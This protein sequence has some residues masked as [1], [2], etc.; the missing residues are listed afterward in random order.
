MVTR[1]QASVPLAF[2][3]R[4]EVISGDTVISGENDTD[5]IYPLGGVIT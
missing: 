2:C 4:F 3:T 1:D 5:F